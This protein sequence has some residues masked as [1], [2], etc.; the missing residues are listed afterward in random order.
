MKNARG[1]SV[2]T[3]R[4]AAGVH[5]VCGV[6]CRIPRTP[7]EWEAGTTSQRSRWTTASSPRTRTRRA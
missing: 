4:F 1:M 3:C 7:G 2:P 5:T 6:V